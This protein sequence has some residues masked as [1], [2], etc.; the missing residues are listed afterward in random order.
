MS[1]QLSI[2]E[3]IFLNQFLLTLNDFKFFKGKLLCGRHKRTFPKIRKV[4]MTP[5]L[6][7]YRDYFY[8]CFIYEKFFSIIS[9]R[10]SV[11]RVQMTV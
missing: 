8:S 11:E 6:K 2:T 7:P 9:N 4:Q 1:K 3:K 5:H 10:F